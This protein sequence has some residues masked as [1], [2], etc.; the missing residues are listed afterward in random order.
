[1]G[2]SSPF[3][4]LNG[5]IGNLY[6]SHRGKDLSERNRTASS[7]IYCSQSE[8]KF[9]EADRISILRPTSSGSLRFGR[10]QI[11]QRLHLNNQ[12][13]SQNDSGFCCK[14]GGL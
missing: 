4:I 9:S 13:H 14:S 7:Q 5:S 2:T 3:L 8:K 1:L 11:R 10:R 12:G 6:M